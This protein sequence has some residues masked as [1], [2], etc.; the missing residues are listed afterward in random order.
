MLVATFGPTT[1]WNGKTIVYENDTFVLEGHG[2][3]Q[4]EDVFEYGR[5]GH[6]VWALSG[7]RA[8]VGARAQAGGGL[9]AA[10]T[11]S[12]ARPQGWSTADDVE[13]LILPAEEEL[14]TPDVD[15]QRDKA[16]AATVSSGLSEDAFAREESALAAAADRA[17]APRDVFWSLA[18]QAVL[19]AEQREDWGR[20]Q[21]L[22]WQMAKWLHAEGRDSLQLARLAR[23][24]E[25]RG[26]AYEGVDRVHAL[27]LDGDSCT[28]CLQ[29][30]GREMSVADALRRMPL[31]NP[32]CEHGWCR[33]C[34]VPTTQRSLAERK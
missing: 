9:V 30:G 29:R 27:D 5:Q 34:W 7:M 18:K 25:L 19:D 3:I 22:Y 16:V 33:C 15:H 20:L 26:Y 24:A 2:P 14:T 21:L 31:P 12:A 1:G 4:A 13:A 28:T 10:A 8:W 32:A 11:A 17:P 23:Q 6:I